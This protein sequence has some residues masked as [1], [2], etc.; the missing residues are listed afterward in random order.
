MILGCYNES[1]FFCQVCFAT[2][3]KP[4]SPWAS[5]LFMAKDHSRCCSLGG[6]PQVET[7]VNGISNRL[8]YGRVDSMYIIFKYSREPQ[9]TTLRAADWRPMS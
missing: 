9:N 6:R 8:N 1:L 5:N 4:R 7:S 3:A 2:F